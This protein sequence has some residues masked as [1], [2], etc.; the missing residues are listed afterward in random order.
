MLSNLTNMEWKQSKSP[1]GNIQW[2]PKD[3]AQRKSVPDAHVKGKFNSPV[4][5]TADIAIKTDLH[6]VRSL[7]VFLQILKN[8]A[9]LLLKHGSS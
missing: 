2:I 6:I 1:A 8:T 7:S 5:T 3:K 4:M 9:L